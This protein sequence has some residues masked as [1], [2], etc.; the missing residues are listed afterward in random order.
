[1]ALPAHKNVGITNNN[2]AE[3][4]NFWLIPH[5]FRVALMTI[6]HLYKSQNYIEKEVLNLAINWYKSR[7]PL[8]QK[9]FSC[10]L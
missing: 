8:T 3:G 6:I 10:K 2:T 7:K 4:V 9:D 1:M 5:S